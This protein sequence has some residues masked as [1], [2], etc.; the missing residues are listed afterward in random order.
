MKSS[1]LV[2]DEPTTDLDP[3]GKLEVFSVIRSLKERQ[4][5]TIIIAE[6]NTEYLA[7]FADRIVVVDEGAIV[8]EGTPEEVFRDVDLLDGIGVPPPEVGRLCRLLEKE[9][10]L[11][12][13]EFTLLEEKLE[14]IIAPRLY[15]KS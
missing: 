12:S 10:L 14:E 13:D 11:K 4:G 5:S 15:H 2:M 8:R 9:D 3:I 7:R 1:I 6:H